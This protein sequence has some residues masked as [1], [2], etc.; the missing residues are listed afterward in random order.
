M[1]MVVAKTGA[2]L[3]QSG[4][5]CFSVSAVVQMY[6]SRPPPSYVGRSSQ[7]TGKLRLTVDRE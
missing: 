3:V 6:G 1:A 5:I 2:L 7:S 4:P